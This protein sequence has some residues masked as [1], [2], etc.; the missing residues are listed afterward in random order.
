V[1]LGGGYGP[2]FLGKSGIFPVFELALRLY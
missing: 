2:S 1:R